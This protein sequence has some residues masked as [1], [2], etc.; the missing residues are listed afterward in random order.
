MWP[1]IPWTSAS[2]RALDDGLEVFAAR[3]NPLHRELKISLSQIKDYGRLKRL[4]ESSKVPMPTEAAPSIKLIKDGIS[5][6]KQ[7]ISLPK[8]APRPD[9]ALLRAIQ[10]PQGGLKAASR[11]FHWFTLFHLMRSFTGLRGG[12]LWA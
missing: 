4:L 12:C 6:A 11:V 2:S 8:I 3:N 10:G 7:G 5:I 9:M 1:F